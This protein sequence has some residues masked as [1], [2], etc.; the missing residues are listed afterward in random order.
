[1]SHPDPR[2]QQWIDAGQRCYQLGYDRDHYI[3]PLHPSL[4][5]AWQ[6]GWDTAALV[7]A[8]ELGA[9]AYPGDPCPYADPALAACWRRG[10]TAAHGLTV[11][12]GSKK[13]G[14]ASDHAQPGCSTQR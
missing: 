3:R 7:A 5:A 12:A 2:I 4:I 11:I 1:M 14:S 6:Y 13:P 9:A 8:V 10:Y